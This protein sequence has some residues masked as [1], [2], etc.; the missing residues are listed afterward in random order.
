MN[1]SLYVGL[2]SGT[3]MDAIDSALVKCQGAE[4]ELQYTHQHP[5]S[6]N[7]RLRIA[8]ISQP[9]EDEIERMGELDRE[10]GRLFA[11]AT[12]ELLAKASISPQ[13]VEAKAVMSRLYATA[14]LQG[15]AI[16][17]RILPFR[18]VTP[19][20]LPSLPKLPPWPTSGAG[21]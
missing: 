11:A 18:L 10:L 20:R 13:Q 7:T 14:H 21:I 6:D 3:S 9:G 8:A 2:M 16:I 19:T 17:Q 4:F 12:M 15:P 1:S 5:I